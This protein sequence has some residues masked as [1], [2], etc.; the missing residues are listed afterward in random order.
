MFRKT[1]FEPGEIILTEGEV[2]DCAYIIDRGM[3]EVSVQREGKTIT[4][5]IL[6]DGDIFGEMGLISNTA[7][8]A[9]VKALAA[10]QVKVICQTFF[11]EKVAKSDPVIERFLCLLLERFHENRNKLLALPPHCWAVM[12]ELNSRPKIET[13]KHRDTLKRFGFINDLQSALERGELRLLYQPIIRLADNRLAG[14]E[15]LVRWEHPQQGLIMPSEFIPISEDT[16]DI[17]PIGYWVF[18]TAGHALKQLHEVGGEQLWMNVNLSPIQL[19]DLS[20]IRR[21]TESLQQI[22]IQPEG[23]RVELTE[24]TLIDD[25]Q[26]SIPFLRK[27]RRLGI[28]LAIDDFGTGYSGLSHLHY[29]PV[30]VLKIDR[31]FV[32]RMVEDYRSREIVQAIVTLSRNLEIDI[33]AEGVE[34]QEAETLLRQLGC[35]YAQGYYYSKPVSLAEAIRMVGKGDF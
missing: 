24:S 27:L 7:R 17:I 28:R 11:H 5:A 30:D 12:D 15:A 4:L 3:V 10:T 21:F 33:I 32:T 35:R 14:F 13:E 19:K 25:P 23:F 34:T 16:K 29:L 8:S 9:T 18:E 6:S 22:G 1:H 20:L 31:S 26:T 2:G